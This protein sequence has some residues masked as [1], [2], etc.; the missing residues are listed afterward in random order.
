MRQDYDVFS[1]SLKATC[2]QGGTAIRHD[3]AEK[4]FFSPVKTEVL[5]LSI[6]C[7]RLLYPTV[8]S[9]RIEGKLTS[10]TRTFFQ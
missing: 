7:F 4:A 5:A 6:I 10:S 3:E 8:F 9:G 2:L 1:S